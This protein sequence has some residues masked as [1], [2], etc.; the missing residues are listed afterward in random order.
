M[1]YPKALSQLLQGSERAPAG[2]EKA[3]QGHEGEATKLHNLLM[4]LYHE[5]E[6][7]NI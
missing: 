2:P 1:L 7:L 6:A 3:A 4:I 5:G